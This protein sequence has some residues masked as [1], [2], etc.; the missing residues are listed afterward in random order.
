MISSASVRLNRSLAKSGASEIRTAK[1]RDRLDQS[2]GADRLGV[3]TGSANTARVFGAGLRPAVSC[4]RI[5]TT[6]ADGAVTISWFTIRGVSVPGSGK[7]P[8]GRYCSTPSA[9]I[10]RRLF[11]MPRGSRAEQHSAGRRGLPGNTPHRPDARVPTSPP[12]SPLRRC[13][14]EPSAAHTLASR[15]ASMSLRG[16]SSKT[17]IDDGVTTH[18]KLFAAP[19]AYS[20][21]TVSSSRTLGLDLSRSRGA[22][23]VSAA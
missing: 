22:G 14:C 21:S 13:D 16:G 7:A 5:A 15:S 18:R 23:W 2:G 1:R 10:S 12:V 11:P 17:S 4:R 6:D 19:S 3:N 9:T 20:S 8:N